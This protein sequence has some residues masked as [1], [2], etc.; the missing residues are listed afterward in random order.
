MMS[1]AEP[2]VIGYRKN[3]MARSARDERMCG[4]PSETMNVPVVVSR[5]L[6]GGRTL[7]LF[8]ENPT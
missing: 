3:V 6:R 1:R 4:R 8:A 2:S 5:S 7:Y